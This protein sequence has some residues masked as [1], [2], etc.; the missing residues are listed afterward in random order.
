MC[1]LNIVMLRFC[2]SKYQLAPQYPHA[3]LGKQ[4]QAFQ[5]AVMQYEEKQIDQQMPSQI[6]T[7]VH[8]QPPKRHPLSK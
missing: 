5:P 1:Q 6:K 7:H 4:D 8:P 3:I 2:F